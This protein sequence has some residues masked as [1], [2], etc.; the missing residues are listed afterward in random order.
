MGVAAEED[1]IIA[2]LKCL[3]TNQNGVLE[4]EEFQNF[5]IVDPYQQKL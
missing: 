1:K 2:M 3:D 4:F 5:V